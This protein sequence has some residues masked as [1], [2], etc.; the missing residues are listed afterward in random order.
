MKFSA[1]LKQAAHF[2]FYFPQNA[3]YF[4][5]LSFSIQIIFTFHKPSIE[6]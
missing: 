4:A 5:I 3:I 1:F 6:I 2:L